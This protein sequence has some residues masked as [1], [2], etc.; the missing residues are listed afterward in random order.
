[1]PEIDEATKKAIDYRITFGKH[2]G[3]TLFQIS[4]DDPKWLD[5]AVD[6]IRSQAVLKHLIH[7]TNHPDIKKRIDAAIF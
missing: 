6:N 5:W 7:A 4:Q 2:K 3:K 1:M